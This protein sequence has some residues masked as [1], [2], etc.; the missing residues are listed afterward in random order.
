MGRVVFLFS[1]RPQ[2]CPPHLT[3]LVE[4]NDLAPEAQSEAEAEVGALMAP[5]TL[6]GIPSQPAQQIR[7]SAAAHP[8]RHALTTG[9]GQRTGEVLTSSCS[10][11]G[12][13]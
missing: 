12:R 7:P 6:P 8:F 11:D 5:L 1:F 10:S 13:T 4:T 9:L 3:S 2:C